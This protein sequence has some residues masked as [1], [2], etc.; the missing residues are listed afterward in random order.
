MGLYKYKELRSLHAEVQ[1]AAY[2]EYLDDVIVQTDQEVQT[3]EFL[4]RPPTPAF[5]PMKTGPDFQCQT[6][7]EELWD[8][9]LEVR[10]ILATLVNKTMEQALIEVISSRAKEWY[11]LSL[12][13]TA[14]EIINDVTQEKQL[15]EGIQNLAADIFIPQSVANILELALQEK[16]FELI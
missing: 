14:E 1:T 11:E 4:D 13:R 12:R 6:D 8:F 15:I 7:P 5:F 2:L 10:P 3:N 9:D 16:A